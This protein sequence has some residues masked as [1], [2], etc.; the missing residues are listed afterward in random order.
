MTF[1]P[2]AFS[3]QRLEQWYSLHLP[4]M[5]TLTTI[6]QHLLYNIWRKSDININS[7]IY[8]SGFKSE[9][10]DFPFQFMK[11]NLNMLNKFVFFNIER[12]EIIYLT[13]DEFN[14]ILLKLVKF[15]HS[16]KYS[17]K[18][19]VRFF[20]GQKSQQKFKVDFGVRSKQ[21]ASIV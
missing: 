13:F 1:D 14:L 21:P 17:H 16:Q 10:K 9:R 18:I 8:I 6:L 7:K 20:S 5:I 2:F 12:Y 11:Y 15:G 19:H 3:Q 4:F